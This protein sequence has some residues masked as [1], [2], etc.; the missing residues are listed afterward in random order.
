MDA[1]EKHDAFGAES[2]QVLQALLP[3]GTSIQLWITDFDVYGR[4]VADVIRLHDRLHI[5]RAM[6]ISGWAWHY[7]AYDGR[8]EV[9]Q[10]ERLARSALAA[11]HG[12]DRTASRH[13]RC[14][15]V[16]VADDAVAFSHAQGGSALGVLGSST[17]GGGRHGVAGDAGT[18]RRR[19]TGPPKGRVLSRRSGCPRDILVVNAAGARGGGVGLGRAHH[20]DA[21]AVAGRPRTVGTARR[22]TAGRRQFRVRGDRSTHADL[23]TALCRG[24]AAVM[25]CAGLARHTAGA[26]SRPELVEHGVHLGSGVA[27][28][29]AAVIVVVVAVADTVAGAAT[30]SGLLVSRG[31]HL[32]RAGH[33]YP[34]MCGGVDD[35]GVAAH[36]Q[37][38]RCTVSDNR[39]PATGVRGDRG[40]RTTPVGQR[41]V[42]VRLR[43]PCNC[44]VGAARPAIPVV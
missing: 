31:D 26:R 9:A 36:R 39:P 18:A 42:S 6:L 10:L 37:R 3:R 16:G 35:A 8:A 33:L 22:R 2:K 25:A 41:A 27:G 17:G 34:A 28:V 38:R 4:V 43:R 5:N 7:A 11:R 30:P 29:V 23:A 24:T 20:G 19:D 15:Q 40:A 21:G 1:P 12:D 32:Q 14:G 13:W 44:A